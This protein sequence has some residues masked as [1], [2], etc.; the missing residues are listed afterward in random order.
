MRSRSFFRARVRLDTR[1]RP[2]SY[3]GAYGLEL[4]GVDIDADAVGANDSLDFRFV[5][6]V[7]RNSKIGIGNYDLVTS[8]LGVERFPDFEGFWRPRSF[9]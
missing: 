1:P 5:D 6:D 2:I 9:P 8:Y 4:S 7:C 3:K